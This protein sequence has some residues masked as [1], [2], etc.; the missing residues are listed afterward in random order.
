[1]TEPIHNKE[2]V[3]AVEDLRN[4]KIIKQDADIVEKM[5]YSKS[6][7]S[8]YIG[9]NVKASKKF[10]KKFENSFGVLLTDYKN[11]DTPLNGQQKPSDPLTG[12]HVTLQD[13]IDDLKRDKATLYALA[14][15]ILDQI[16]LDTKATLAYQMAWVEYEAERAAK[17][18]EQLKLELIHKMNTLVR[19]YLPGRAVVG[20]EIETGRKGKD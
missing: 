5:G 10:L 4:R 18:D 3:A 20:S 15:S 17:G 7:V 6:T 11:G 14:N 9:G 1:M 13:Y 19:S 16:K 2:L 8:G 12:A